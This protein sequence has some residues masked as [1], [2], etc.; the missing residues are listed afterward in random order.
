MLCANVDQEFDYLQ[1]LLT[2]HGEHPLATEAWTTLAEVG[3]T[4]SQYRSLVRTI[5]RAVQ[6]KR[7]AS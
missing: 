7:P 3:D 2:H 6:G 4:L 1:N 5:H